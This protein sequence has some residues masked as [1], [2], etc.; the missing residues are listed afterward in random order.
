MGNNIDSEKLYK[1]F[2]WVHQYVSK[3]DF[4]LERN[5]A[6][7]AMEWIVN[8][9]KIVSVSQLVDIFHTKIPWGS[10]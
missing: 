1:I 5:M 9:S 10:K 2:I 6:L 8:S 4:V 3:L 7:Q